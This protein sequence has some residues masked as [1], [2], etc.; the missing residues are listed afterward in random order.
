MYVEATTA[1]NG[2][3]MVNPHGQAWVC[4]FIDS[5]QNP[6]F[7][8][9]V[10]FPK[11]GAGWP[12]RQE[13]V[14]R[15]EEW[16]AGLDWADARAEW[17]ANCMAY[18][19]APRWRCQHEHRD[20]IIEYLA[21]PV[22]PEARGVVGRRIAIYPTASGSF[23]GDVAKMR[24]KLD[25]KGGNKYSSLD[26]PLD[27]PLVVALQ[28]WHHVDQ[29]D[30]TNALFGSEQLTWLEDRVA[31]R[32]VPGSIRTERIPDGYWRPGADPRGTRISAVLFG[33]T[34]SA[35][36]VTSKLPELWLNPW[37][38]TP[39][40]RLEPFQTVYVDADNKLAAREATDTA[41]AVFKLPP[42]WPNSSD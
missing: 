36:S 35:S 34:L 9:G 24:A 1:F 3:N 40:S 15:L 21:T 8:V 26:R 12:G 30:L 6:D 22:Q 41:A 33:N 11:V 7:R 13:I 37:A 23:M 10:E 5:A 29:F 28:L 16:L 25:D 2:D 39:L 31:D 42:E 19:N 20:W 27:K 38:S 14:E 32:V 17:D 18:M 4:D